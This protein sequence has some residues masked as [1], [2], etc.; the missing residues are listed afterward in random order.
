MG[1]GSGLS[2]GNLTWQT[3][4]TIDGLGPAGGNSHCSERSPDGSKEQEYVTVSSYVPKALLNVM[5][6]KKLIEAATQ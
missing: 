6:I 4:P 1:R 5:A 2:D 3:I